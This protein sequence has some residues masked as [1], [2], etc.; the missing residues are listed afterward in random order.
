MFNN[1]AGR[2]RHYVE[3]MVE[4]TDTDDWG[5]PIGFVPVFDARANVQVTSGQQNSDYGSVVT[6]EIITVLCRYDDRAQN[7]QTIRW[8]GKDYEVQHVRPDE[9]MKDMIITA[10]SVKR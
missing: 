9:R 10:E 5:D 8:N 7:N 2:M 3:F 6:S 1:R 4:S